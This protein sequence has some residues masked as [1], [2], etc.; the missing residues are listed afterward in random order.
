LY[1]KVRDKIAQ[2]LLLELPV[3]GASR[4]I[5]DLENLSR[6]Y[7]ERGSPISEENLLAVVVMMDKVE[8]DADDML[9]KDFTADYSVHIYGSVK[10]SAEGRGDQNS[11]ALVSAVGGIVE[12]VLSYGGYNRLG[13]DLPTAANNAE[14]V[15]HRS[16]YET[17]YFNPEDTN[18]ARP[19]YRSVVR[20]RVKGSQPQN[21]DDPIALGGVDTQACLF[22]SS[23]CYYYT[24]EGTPP[25]TPQ[26]DNNLSFLTV[27]GEEFITVI[28]GSLTDISLVDDTGADVTP[29]ISG[30]QLTVTSVPEG[31]SSLS[32]PSGKTVSYLP[33]DDGFYKFGRLVDFFTLKIDNPFE[34][35]VRFTD[36]DGLQIYG[37][38]LICDWAQWDRPTGAFVMYRSTVNSS[39]IDFPSALTE[40]SGL[41][42]GGYN[43]WRMLDDPRVDAVMSK[44]FTGTSNGL[45][46]TP[47]AM[48]FVRLWS[49][50]SN[51]SS[52]SYEYQNNGTKFSNNKLT[53][54]LRR[55]GI[56]R[57]GNVSELIP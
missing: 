42:D 47:F 27:N 16:V 36:T 39:D 50:T 28:S 5:V 54:T 55:Y 12:G 8:F 14:G 57:V 35:P 30:N 17:L 31:V 38:G 4:G 49:A 44:D 48:V 1:E 24:T 29:V 23:E 26:P 11:S 20:L 13:M 43:D 25:P 37:N 3:Q 51:S 41:L 45:N 21:Y 46:Y 7:V 10:S 18:D 40:I 2:I 22:N 19:I 33:G 52:F 53:G 15:S 34:S 32:L 6:V 9:S 56:Y